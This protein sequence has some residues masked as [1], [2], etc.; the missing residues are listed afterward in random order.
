MQFNGFYE[1]VM[2]FQSKASQNVQF[3]YTYTFYKRLLNTEDII[4]IGEES[5]G[6]DCALF[7]KI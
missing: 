3:I 4:T 7:L 5:Y 1:M 2:V 6:V